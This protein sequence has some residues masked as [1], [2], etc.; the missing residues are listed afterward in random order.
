VG[1]FI[2]WEENHFIVGS[3]HHTARKQ[4]KTTKRKEQERRGKRFS[5][6]HNKKRASELKKE[7]RETYIKLLK[8]I[9]C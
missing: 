7:A 3:K 5:N 6:I 2:D 9:T 1:R 4:N 8:Q